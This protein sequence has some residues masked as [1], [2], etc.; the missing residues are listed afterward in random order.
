MATVADEQKWIHGT[1]Q[2]G[3]RLFL[4]G[5]PRKS[6]PGRFRCDLCDYDNRVK[7]RERFGNSPG[8]AE[9]CEIT[10]E[11]LIAGEPPPYAH[12]QD[13]HAAVRVLTRQGLSIRE[14]ALRVGIS[15]RQV[16]VIRKK[17]REGIPYGTTC[18]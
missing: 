11:R 6:E 10:Q 12:P 16:S 13:R 2:K 14:T 9:P 18:L 4:H 5:S 1:C 3:H 8:P 17:L 7:Y 15:T